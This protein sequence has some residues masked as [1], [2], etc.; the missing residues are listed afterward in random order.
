VG[1]MLILSKIEDAD[2]VAEYKLEVGLQRD[3]NGINEGIRFMVRDDLI[4]NKLGVVIEL[5]ETYRPTQV[6]AKPI[7]VHEELESRILEWRE[8]NKKDE[9]TT[10]DVALAFP[11]PQY[12]KSAREK[13]LTELCNKNKIKRTT[14]GH[15]KKHPFLPFVS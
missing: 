14:R 8:A 12:S 2:G 10:E 11:T 4:G 6:P 15:Y 9:F 7:K 13:A 1:T 3:N 5:I